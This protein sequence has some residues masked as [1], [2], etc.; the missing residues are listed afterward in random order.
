MPVSSEPERTQVR[1]V[2]PYCGVGCGMI[3][4]VED[5]RVVGVSGDKAHPANFGS[6]CTK[7]S[8]V[9]QTL[10][11]PGRLA[12]PQVRRDEDGRFERVPWDDA[13]GVVAEGFQRTIAAHGPDAVALYVSGQ[14]STETQYLA[15]KLTK[16]FFRT[17]N[18]DTN[19]RLCMASAAAGYKTSLGADGPPG[20]YE[21][22]EHANL[23]FVIGSNMAE[24]HPILFQ[25]MRRRLKAGGAKLLV[26]DPRRTATAA[27]A[28]LFLPV[29]PGTDLALLN[30][31][32][33]L[34]VKMG[35]TDADFIARHTEGWEELAAMLEDYP[36]ARVAER[37]GLRLDDLLLAAK[38]IADATPNFL[39]LWTMGINQSTRGTWGSNAVCNLHLATGAIGRPGGG[40]FSLTG[41]PNA[42]GGREV[43]YMVGGLPGQRY[44]E[45]ARDRAKTEALWELPEGAIQPRPGLAAVGLFKAIEDGAVKALWVIGSNPLA[46]MPNRERVRRALERVE[47]LVVQDAYHPTETSALAH[48]LLP[49]AV[50]AEAEG[51]MV[52]SSRMVTFM[53]RAVP[54]PGEARPDWEIISQVARRMGFGASFPYQNAGEVFAEVGRSH[55]PRTGYDVRGMSHGRLANDGALT[56]P[57]APGGTETK[58]RYVASGE[59]P[60]SQIPNLRFPTP[61]GRAQFHA[62]PFVPDG[63]TPDE[64]FPFV[65]TTGRLAHQWH[66][67]T[68][69]G[70]VP[71]LNK[72]NPGPFLQVHPDDAAALGVLRD[73]EPVRVT[74]RQG[75]A[76]LPARVD[77]E[78]VPG[79]CWAPIHWTEHG[80]GIN[81]VTS[82]A[83]DPV[84]LQPELKF[85]P[86]RLEVLR[87]WEVGTRKSEVI[88]ASR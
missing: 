65:L 24:C 59:N 79:C 61:S 70:R 27:D 72:L 15:N 81:S 63:D 10:R 71:A 54:P 29:R 26:A 80:A 35:R 44:V 86:V 3:L 43:G 73:G 77:A 76:V 66:T 6:L 39:T 32:L 31:L 22:F 49:G 85:C 60:K 25:R 78:I 23:F 11:G 62:R 17:N 2:C 52:N 50:W 16:G 42:M 55:N 46:T 38:L 57:L 56:W 20:H 47:L 84:S 45:N 68:K 48:V 19:S 34:L 30:G 5:G 69:T 12:Y 8:T 82:E 53:P 75:T 41:Q 18:I 58:R 33:H 64:R 4:R 1:T 87:K 9:D 74:S 51:T 7:G 83:V 13:L 88:S 40:P 37:C 36:P 21:D 28:D 14:L 67:R